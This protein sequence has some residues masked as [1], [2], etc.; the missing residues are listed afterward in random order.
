MGRA[1]APNWAF[2]AASVL[3][4]AGPGSCRFSSSFTWAATTVPEHSE[5][6]EAPR[7]GRP[8]HHEDVGSHI[9]EGHRSAGKGE[10]GGIAEAGPDEGGDH[11]EDL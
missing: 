9:A 6:P 1:A 8:N 3:T 5:H 4:S 11:M 2:G 10:C 7:V